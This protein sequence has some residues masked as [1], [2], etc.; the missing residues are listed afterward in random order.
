MTYFKIILLKVYF[1]NWNLT[2]TLSYLESSL[3][4]TT[5]YYVTFTAALLVKDTALTHWSLEGEH[6]PVRIL[7]P[8]C[9]GSALP[10]KALLWLHLLKF[11]PKEGSNRARSQKRK[12]KDVQAQQRH[13]GFVSSEVHVIPQA[14]PKAFKQH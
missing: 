12:V 7:A 3:L 6:S 5:E 4:E 8:M 10:C 1:K 11:T 2:K 9:S 13:P 14:P